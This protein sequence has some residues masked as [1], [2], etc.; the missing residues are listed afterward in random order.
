MTSLSSFVKLLTQPNGTYTGLK[1]MRHLLVNNLL[2]MHNIKAFHVDLSYWHESPLFPHC[3]LS[4][5]LCH[6]N[7]MPTLSGIRPELNCECKITLISCWFSNTLSGLYK[8]RMDLLNIN[9]DVPLL[10]PMLPAGPDQLVTTWL[11]L[12]NINWQVSYSRISFTYSRNIKQ[13]PS[14]RSSGVQRRWVVKTSQYI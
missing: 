8:V 11:C 14:T 7:S 13:I 10:T 3:S 9:N 6:Y 4:S 2:V 5:L 12:T 1:P